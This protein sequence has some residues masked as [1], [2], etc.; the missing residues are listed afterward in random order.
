MGW[1]HCLGEPGRQLSS[2]HT[3]SPTWNGGEHIITLYVLTKHCEWRSCSHTSEG[4]NW[5]RNATGTVLLPWRREEPPDDGRRA[6]CSRAPCRRFPLE[7]HRSQM[8]AVSCG[9]KWVKVPAEELGG[10]LTLGREGLSGLPHHKKPA[11]SGSVKGWSI[12]PPSPMAAPR[13]FLPQV[14]PPL[15]RSPGPAALPE[16]AHRAQLVG[17]LPFGQLRQQPEQ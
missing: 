2:P 9:G 11:R 1:Q 10:S 16:Q 5:R 17:T 12:Y 15:L 14:L 6:R 4:A 13:G 8:G 7:R 3:C